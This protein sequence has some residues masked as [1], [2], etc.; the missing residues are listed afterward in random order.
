MS[1]KVLVCG[2][3]GF[4]MSN[5]IRYVLY[6]DSDR[7]YKFASVDSLPGPEDHKR[8]YIHRNHRFHIGD[9]CDP[10]F[11]ERIVSIEKP[12]VIVN[13]VGVKPTVAGSMRNVVN[14]ALTLREVAGGTRII[15]IRPGRALQLGRPTQACWDFIG[16]LAVCRSGIEL[17]LPRCFGM[18]DQHG[19][20]VGMLRV[21]LN[22]PDSSPGPEFS[23][24]KE[25]W[26]YAEDVASMI[27]FLIETGAEGSHIMPGLG[28][29]SPFQ[30]ARVIDEALE[31]SMYPSSEHCS[32]QSLHMDNTVY[33]EGWKPDSNSMKQ[34]LIKTAKWFHM[35]RWALDR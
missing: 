26:A 29:A 25:E 8:V 9:A 18:R 12:D 31:L 10:E 32:E 7:Q 28:C 33:P 2:S 34:A 14:T 3:A 17:S 1:T 24:A 20:V 23:G 5:L 35:N 21:L 13:A 4:L 27:W 30:M 19:Q 11:M 6:R 15:Q 22:H 16:A